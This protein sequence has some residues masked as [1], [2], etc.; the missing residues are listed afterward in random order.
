MS[1]DEDAQTP[2]RKARHLT[3]TAQTWQALSAGA[4]FLVLALF[5]SF[6]PVPY[7]VWTPGSAVDLNAQASGDVPIVDPG[8]DERTT[9]LNGHLYMVTI[10]SSRTDSLVSLP[11]A[12]MAHALPKRDVLP[13]WELVPPGKDEAQIKAADQIAMANSQKAAIAAGLVTA[14][15]KVPQRAQVAK[16]VT[17]GPSHGKL[18]V[19]DFLVT[20]DGQQVTVPSDV[21]N[22]I[23]NQ[24]KRTPGSTIN[25]QVLRDGARVSVDVTLAA[26]NEDKKTPTLGIGLD[27]GYDFSG[28]KAKISTDPGI[29]GPSA[30]LPFALAIYD[31]VSPDD[32]LHGL[33]VAATGEITP[34]GQ[35]LPV[36][37]V[38]Q[39]IGAAES[40]KVQA[41][42]I[43]AANCAD[44]AG[45]PTKI[46]IIP[47]KSLKDAISAI[48]ALGT[49]T[50]Q[51][52]VPSCS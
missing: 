50:E 13:R 7:I 20:V 16:V 31:Q 1:H 44:A 6:V 51:A 2:P 23:I 3:L 17:T 9:A 26:A 36:G 33:S 47:V 49:E 27:L 19:G 4:L 42:L 29:G 15:T 14:G 18:E 38:Q 8:R 24:K 25:I 46:R 30:G 28:T 37:G 10:S 35:V 45:V 21:Q 48:Q 22:I 11:E 12:L 5:I 52:A 39:K 32:V 40:A 43:P 41:I 34:T